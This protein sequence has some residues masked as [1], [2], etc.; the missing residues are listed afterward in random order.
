MTCFIKIKNLLYLTEF[1]SLSLIM[2]EYLNNYYAMIKIYGMG[3][4]PDCTYVEEQVKG[5][6]LI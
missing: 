6:D 3:T 2:I 1:L 5:N 4:C